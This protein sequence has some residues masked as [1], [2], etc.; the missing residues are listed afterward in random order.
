MVA[1]ITARWLSADAAGV[2]P[3]SKHR[4]TEDAGKLSETTL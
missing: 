4:T 3:K 2:A 1:T